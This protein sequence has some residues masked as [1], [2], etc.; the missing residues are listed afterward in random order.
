MAQVSISLDDIAPTAERAL[1]EVAAGAAATLHDFAGLLDAR[2]A[3]LAAAANRLKETLGEDHPKVVA[4][5]Q[6]AAEA[7]T[8]GASARVEADR[9]SRRPRLEPDRW[10]LFGRVLRRDGGP[11]S[12][13]RVRV[14]NA[15]GKLKVT[16][17]GTTDELGDFHVTYQQQDFP[18]SPQEVPELFVLV[19]N[20]KGGKLLQSEHGVRFALGR[21]EFAEIT[22]DDRPAEPPKAARAT[23]QRSTPKR[24]PRTRKSK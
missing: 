11:A 14:T 4:L 7:Q 5:E 17:T 15:D 19:E 16:P 13:V 23:R 21:A 10:L 18:E 1:D 2:A 22:V 12:D 24:P 20:A 3:R 9:Q 6:A 8:L